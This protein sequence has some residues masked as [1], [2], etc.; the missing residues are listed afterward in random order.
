MNSI[1][2]YSKNLLSSFLIVMGICLLC[3]QNMYSQFTVTDNFRGSGSPDIIIGDDAYLTS[4]I[5]DPVNAGWLRLTKALKSQKGYAYINKSFPSTLGVII[6]F[7]YTM[8]RNEA[9]GTYHGADG[10]SIFLFDA[11]YGPGNFSLGAYGSSLG[12]AN[13]TKTSPPTGGL[14]GGYIGIGFDAYGNFVNA[15]EGKNG[16]STNKSPNSIAIRGATT[17]TTPSD[18]DTNKYL[19]GLTLLNDGSSEDALTMAGNARDNVID[20]NITSSVRPSSSQ[21]Y[22]R[23]Q[24]EIVPTEAGKY[25]IT[26]RW[27]KVEGG[28]FTDLIEYETDDAPPSLL[29]LGFAA[30][31]GGGFNNHE[32]RNLLV[33]TPGNLRVVKKADKN[34]LRSINAGNDENEVTY[35]IEVVNDTD[36]DLQ[37]IAFEDKLTDG[38]GEVLSSNAF[39]I[40]NITH[41][42]FKQGTELPNSSATNEFTGSLN[43]AAN[44]TGRI[45]VTGI[46]KKVAAGNVITNTSSALPT[47][48]TDEDIGNNT[49][50]V[51]IPIIA[52]GVDL[53]VEKSVDQSCLDESNGN[54]FKLKVSN[55]GA[56][57]LSYSSRNKVVVTEY[58]PAGATISNMNH[59]GWDYVPNGNTLTF[60]KSGSGTLGSGLSLPDISYTLVTSS[61]SGYT[62]TGNVALNSDS[63]TTEQNIEPQENRGNNGNSLAILPRPTAPRLTSSVVYYCQGQLTTPLS[64]DVDAGFELL[65]YL[66]EGGASSKTAF[67]PDSRTLGTT[68]Y[69]VAQSN[70]S[71][72]SELVEIE[73][74]VAAAPEAGSIF[75]DAIICSGAKPQ[76]LSSPD[77]GSG[78]GTVSYKW[79]LSTDNGSTWQEIPGANDKT[80]QPEAVRT[81]TSYRRSTFSENPDGT[82]CVSE[83]TAPVEITIKNCAVLSN[84]MLPSKAINISI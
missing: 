61:G 60:E 3:S 70:G 35:N 38:N 23:V 71:C 79:E 64:A 24:V 6:D 44:S 26:V 45:K 84:P 30:S 42:G 69:Y 18:T 13:N 51:N 20:Y 25:L 55:L 14:T 2:T 4:G 15:S 73:V 40:S 56:N 46:L 1:I 19:K 7:E 58:I 37:N 33:T 52:E 63:G 29:K 80:Y 65:W 36:V 57:I 49:S 5:D 78:A 8:W 81:Q 12:Y 82:G 11:A 32:I 43:L 50:T 28:G 41:T 31:T 77:D 72:Q 75:G 27:S 67:T 59:P 34:I 66:N 21:F 74:I 16:G 62:S 54:V 17:S 47:D 53:V 9:D 48:I 10:F 76:E 68:T 83:A 22:R 39:E